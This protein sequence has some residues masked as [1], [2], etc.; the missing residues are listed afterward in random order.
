M[1]FLISCVN[2]AVS[3]VGYDMAIKAPFWYCPANRLRSCGISIHGGSL[4]VA[5]DGTLTRI[6]KSGAK[7]QALPGPHDNFAHSVHQLGNGLTG[8]AD[9][10]NS[11]IL[12]ISGDSASLAMSPL[13]GWRDIPEDAI[14]LNDFTETENGIITSAFSYQP[15]S[16]WRHS[17]LKWQSSGWGVLFEM[18][19]HKGKTISRVVATGLNCPHSLVRHD[20]DIFCCSSSMGELCRLRPDSDGLYQFAGKT[21]VTDSHFLRGLLRIEEGWVLGGSS[22]RRQKDGIGMCLYFLSD[23]GDVEYLPLAGPGEI[24]DILPWDD[25]LMPGIADRLYEL[26]VID[27]LEGEYPEICKLPDNYR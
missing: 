24:Y 2:S 4:W 12:L 16:D 11:R 1:K 22:R 23:S 21:K 6:D 27:D 5:T 25:E 18:K 8:V 10:G 17:E 20:G 19:R 13:D 3:L 14:H 15:F 7:V 9:T 26:P